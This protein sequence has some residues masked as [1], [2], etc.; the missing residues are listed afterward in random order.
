MSP[1]PP[2][3]SSPPPLTM[4]QFWRDLADE[5]LSV[6]RGLP[7]TFLRLC[8]HPG[9]LVRDYVRHRDP[10]IVRPLR[11]FLIGVALLA[12]AFQASGASDAAEAGFHEGFRQ[13][14]GGTAAAEAVWWVLSHVEW[15]LVGAWLPATATA[16][17]LAFRRSRPDFAEAWVLGLYVTG[18]AFACMAVLV[19][20]DVGLDRLD[21]PGP[22]FWGLWAL[23]LPLPVFLAAACAGFFEGTAPGRWWRAVASVLLALVG[24]AALLLAVAIIAASTARLLEGI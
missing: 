3:P 15:W 17:C 21:V 8:R 6:E 1:T 10:R 7:W 2:L 13:S 20:L 24:T 18:H 19:M 12:L 11:Y 16:V 9:R 5:L 22:P 4:R 23:L 14:E